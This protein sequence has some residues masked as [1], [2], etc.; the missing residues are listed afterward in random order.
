M[1]S[2]M[3]NFYHKLAIRLLPFKILF[4]LATFLS[5][6]SFFY[7][8]FTAKNELDDVFLLL[9]V[10]LTI[11][12]LNL[13]VLINYFQKGFEE[14]VPEGFFQ[15]IKQKLSKVITWAI[16]IILTLSSLALLNLTLKI[17]SLY[18]SL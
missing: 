5:V 12:S 10:A 18:N 3:L 6:C 7:I 14:R 17:V 15:K 16:A 9:S 11:W 13:I 8:L 2:T 4:Q 1:F